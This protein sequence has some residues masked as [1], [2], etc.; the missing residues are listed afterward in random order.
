MLEAIEKRFPLRWHWLH[1]HTKL[2][3]SSHRWMH[4]AYFLAVSIDG[5]G[6]Y[7]LI[8]GGLFVLGIVEFISG[9]EEEA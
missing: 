2:L 3:Q 8:A 1:V 5:H 9:T 6:R 7:A 4:L